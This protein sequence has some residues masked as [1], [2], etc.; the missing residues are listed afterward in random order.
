MGLAVVHPGSFATIQDTGRDGF[1]AFGVPGGGSF[2]RASAALANALLGNP[3]GCAVLELTLAGGVFEALVPLALALAGAPIEAR[4]VDADGRSAQL[5]PPLAFPLPAGERLVLGA[6]ARGARSYLAVLG[7][8]QTPVVLGSRST[9]SPLRAGEIIPA[10][11][12]WTAVRHPDARDNPFPAGSDRPLRVVAGPDFEQL[13]ADAFGPGFAFQVLPR[14]DRMGLRLGG[15]GWEIPVDPDRV[16]TPVA[17][18]AVQVA[19]GR[20]MILGVA[21][22]TMGGYPHVAHVVSADIGRVAQARPGDV[23]RFEQ[24]ALSEARRLDGEARRD[25]AARLHRIATAAADRPEPPGS[26]RRD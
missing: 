2:D 26:D 14:S 25:L 6:M 17:P 11:S 8:W 7:G 22:G 13:P 18:G 24:V 3:D 9:E 12:G 10:R 15:P 4:R 19:G 5:D 21:C 1:R 16:S 20:P 23:L